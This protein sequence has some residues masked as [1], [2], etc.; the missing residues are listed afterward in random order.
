MKQSMWWRLALIVVLLAGW[1]YSMFPVRNRDFMQT[2]DKLAQ[3]R[4]RAL[5]AQKSQAQQA[6]ADVDK[7]LAAIKD[8]TSVTA[9][10]LQAQKEKH[11]GQELDA[12]AKLAQFD[13]M[14][15]K[16]NALLKAKEQAAPYLAVKQAAKGE[17]GAGRVKLLDFIPVPGQGRA[18]NDL[19]LS[20]VR[21]QAAGKFHLGLDLRGGTEFVIGFDAKQVPAERKV[22]EVRDQILEILRNRV[23]AMGVAEPEIKPMGPTSISLRMPSVSEN[24]KE[25]IRR[26]IKS[27]AKLEFHIVHSESARLVADYQRAPREFVPE[28]GYQYAEMEVEREGQQEIEPLFMRSRPE[29]VK[30]EDLDRAIPTFNEFGNYSVSLRFNSQGAV[31]FA[32]VTTESTGKRM[33]IVLDGK[34]YSAPVIREPI[35]GGNAEI[36]GSFSPEEAQQLAV[37]L[38]CGRLPVSITIDSEFGTDPTLGADSIRAGVIA[39]VV[40]SLAVVLFML[41][42]Y[43]LSGVNAIIALVANMVLL[44]GTMTILGSTFTMP[45]L[46]GIVLTVGM[47]VDANI[48]IFERIREELAAG[49][50]LPN[51][52]Q[53]GF[54][55]AFLTIFDS[56]MTTLITALILLA[57]GSGS[58]KGFA[59]TLSIGLI[60]NVFTAVFFSRLLFEFMLQYGGLKRITMFQL[61]KRPNL[62]V[63][64]W[65]HVTFT[66]SGILMLGSVILIAV[67]GKDCL[68]TDFVGG[69]TLTYRYDAA[70]T[71]PDASAVRAVVE[72]LGEK[73]VRVGYKYAGAQQEPLLEVMVPTAAAG[74]EDMSPLKLLTAL[75]GTFVKAKFEHVQMYKVGGLVGAKFQRGAIIAV[76]LSWIAITLYVA[77]RFEVA[78]GV[79]GVIALIHDVTIATG[80]CVLCGRQISLTVLAAILTIIGFSIN[81]T[82][83]VFDRIREGF[84]LRGN[85]PYAEVVRRSINETLSRTILTSTTVMFTLLALFFLGGGAINDFALVMIAGVFFGT[86]SSVYIASAIIVSWHKRRPLTLPDVQTRKVQ[87]A[88]VDDEA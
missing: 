65:R 72:G 1:T 40:G 22:E 39:A 25:E 80:V 7:R 73:D 35:T 13:T 52:I 54:S 38:Q 16:A 24:E 20:Y 87:A 81:D 2:M 56:N 19:V 34:V 33:A 76:I 9:A 60:V 67:K 37:V 29:R 78:Y 23:D 30:G 45:G 79:A 10:Q 84:T 15:A 77:F 70:V 68:S 57:M 47:A 27:T 63:L 64:R 58:V 88:V 18:S 21:R 83:V 75:N 49:K 32:E 14:V 26:L 6:M 61:L 50:T 48:L 44:I 71:P 66:I 17:A 8:K 86:Y 5:T 62:D 42:Y 51:A 28:A 36:S 43:H 46:A 74:K 31:A 12:A 11:Q 41:V 69:T 55:R 82:V 4:L 85:L 59:I 3:P 53:A